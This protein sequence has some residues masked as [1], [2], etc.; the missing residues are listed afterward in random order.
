MVSAA[1]SLLRPRNAPNRDRLRLRSLPVPP[2]RL[3]VHCS[4]KW[5][6]SGELHAI[7][8]G[9]AAASFSP[10]GD[11]LP[12]LPFLLIRAVRP[13]INGLGAPIPLRGEFC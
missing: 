9:G 1:P 5:S 7:G 4:A 11:P 3:T 8:N 10:S 2:V 6:N 12:S 13:L